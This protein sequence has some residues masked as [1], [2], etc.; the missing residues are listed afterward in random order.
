MNEELEANT[1]RVIGQIPLEML[2]RVIENWSV[3][4]DHVIR[5]HDQ[6]LKETILKKLL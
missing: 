6:H 1:T 4:M 2:G 3:Q 5:S